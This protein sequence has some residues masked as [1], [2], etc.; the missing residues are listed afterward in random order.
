[1]TRKKILLI[2][3]SPTAILWQRLI[4][5]DEPYEILV[6]GDGEEGIRVAKSERPDLVLLDVVMPRMSGFDTLRALRAEGALHDVPILMVTTRGE[7]DN[8]MEGFE[9]GCNEYITKPVDRAELL[10]KVRSYMQ[11]GEAAQ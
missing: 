2:D 10:T 6:A 3:D 1:V 8:V 7:M 9:S 11:R 4:L 5:E